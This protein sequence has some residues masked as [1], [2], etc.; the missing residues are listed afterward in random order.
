M[1]ISDP[2]QNHSVGLQAPLTAA[3]DIIPADGTDLAVLPRAVL[4]GSGGDLAVQFP[5]GG[6]VVL[7]DLA[8]GTLYPLR[9][10]RVLATGT[11]AA[12]IVGLY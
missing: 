3:F 11:T 1:P 7:R 12:Q 6:S 10:M 5:D 4:V 2:F 9:V 8:P